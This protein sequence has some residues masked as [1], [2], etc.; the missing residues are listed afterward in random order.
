MASTS[1]RYFTQVLSVISEF[2]ISEEDCLKIAGLNK[3]PATDRVDASKLAYI[4]NFAANRLNE[5]SM[6]IK[7]GLKYPILQFTR[8]AEFLKLCADLKHAADVYT[9][10]SP[11]FHT[12]GTPSGIISE[13]GIDRMIWTPNLDQSE[14]VEYRQFIELIMTN[15]VT[16]INWL[17]WKTPNAVQ[18]INIKHAASLPLRKYKGL[19]ECEVRFDQE[20]Y[21]LILKEGVKDAPFSLSDE[22]ELAKVLM[23][24]DLALNELFETESLVDRIELQ[25][26]RTI[27]HSNPSKASVAKALG[28]SER[29]MARDLKSIGTSFKVIKNGVLKNLALAKIRQGLPLVEVAHSLGYN[30]QPAFTRA[31]KKWFGSSPR[32]HNASGVS[33]S[34]DG[35]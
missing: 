34:L 13:N 7:C 3:F 5:P 29:T 35:K 4:L 18:Q 28:L 23:K 1:L 8:P 21:S 32:K 11:L 22:K 20:E 25:I 24:F 12:V 17:S 33:V 19:F 26:L 15:L 27:E 30:D 2:N 14:I 31:Y 16:S 10:Y 9:K 6:G